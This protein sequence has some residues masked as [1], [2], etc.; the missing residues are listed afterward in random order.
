MADTLDVG[1]LSGRIE[2]EDNTSGTIDNLSGKVDGLGSK[3]DTM[4]GKLQNVKQGADDAGASFASFS[5]QFEEVAGHIVERLTVY[6]ALRATF[7]TLKEAVESAHSIELLSQQ[8]GIAADELQVLSLAT[9][10]YGID[11]NQLGQAIFQLSRRI[12]GGDESVVTA[13][14]M[15]GISLKDVDG[16]NG[17]ELFLKVERGLATLQGT[18]Q[19]AAASDL[20]GGRLGKS[21]IAFSGD[22][23]QAIA[24]ARNLNA[25]MSNDTTKTLSDFSVNLEKTGSKLLQIAGGAIKPFAYEFNELFNTV[26]TGK[27]D[28]DRF[29]ESL[30]EQD[31]KIAAAGVNVVALT[32]AEQEKADADKFLTTLQSNLISEPLLAWQ[33]KDL[34]QLKDMGQANAKN[35]ESLGVNV[36]QF[37]DW[38]AHAASAEAAAKKY[39]DAIKD[40]SAVGGSYRDTLNGIDG[41]TVAAVKYYLDAGVSQEKLATAYGLTSEQVK[42]V[43]EERKSET[44]GLKT[45]LAAAT[46]AASAEAALAK[47]QLTDQTTILAM[48]EKNDETYFSQMLSQGKITEEQYRNDVIDS[49]TQLARQEEQVYKQELQ[50]ELD[51]LDKKEADA[52]AKLQASYDQGKIDYTDY[53]KTKSDLDQEFSDKRQALE[54]KFVT[55]EKVRQNTLQQGFQSLGTTGQQ[56]FQLIDEADA[57]LNNDIDNTNKKVLELDGTLEDAAKVKEQLDSGGSSDVTSANF[58]NAIAYY[59]NPVAGTPA[60]EY[61]DPYVLAKAGYSFQE[62]VAY[63]FNANDQGPLPP[64]QGPKIPG[65]SEG[66]IGDFGDGT[67]AVLHGPEA[68]IPLDSTSSPLG[69]SIT[70]HFY[71]NGT[72]QQL[73]QSIAQTLMTQLKQ[74]RLFGAA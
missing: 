71:V 19:D 68:I 15:M 31:K 14:S 42:A 7:D 11:N 67:L 43:A 69:G 24:S 29:E 58:D 35:A 22:A 56:S 21:L 8:T 39:N 3:F 48:R 17:E 50:A 57:L 54:D 73:A 33:E 41:E 34:Q 70:N 2:L 9:Q 72:A 36:V 51:D 5:D 61:R 1:T 65:F 27:T 16:L 4:G 30:D 55:D 18:A 10:E 38:E 63:A 47:Q 64:P 46:A 28:L 53:V 32:K 12:A 59:T 44:E 23:D 49:R 74:T 25:S 26:T 40:L 66:G 52:E 45:E 13:L 6:E 20:F 62:I 60:K 37:K